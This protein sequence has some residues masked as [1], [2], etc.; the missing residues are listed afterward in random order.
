MLAAA[1][2][3]ERTPPAPLVNFYS[4]TLVRIPCEGK[5]FQHGV[6]TN[7]ASTK[8]DS[9]RN[10]LTRNM[11]SKLSFRGPETDEGTLAKAKGAIFSSVLDAIFRRCA[12][13]RR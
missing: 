6:G 9:S 7:S 12:K 3:R 8:F 11:K 10:G 13:E 4:F 1:E 5:D 2:R